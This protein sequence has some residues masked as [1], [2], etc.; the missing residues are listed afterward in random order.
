MAF[1]K[2]EENRALVR[3]FC[4]KY[5]GHPEEKPGLRENHTRIIEELFRRLRSGGFVDRLEHTGSAY[6]GLEIGPEREFDLTFVIKM[7]DMTITKQ[8]GE[9]YYLK[10]TTATSAHGDCLSSLNRITYL[11]PQK[12]QKKFYSLFENEAQRISDDLGLSYRIQQKRHGGTAIQWDVYEGRELLYSVD[13]VP[14]I[15]EGKRY[16]MV[17]YSLFEYYIIKGCNHL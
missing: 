3:Q 2:Q 14:A 1:W 16:S 8:K 6:T 4:D 5:A 9:M 7:A 13:L 10:T 11:D 12:L 15:E 17:T